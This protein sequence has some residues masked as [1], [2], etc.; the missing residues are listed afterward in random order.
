MD[1]KPFAL[2]LSEHGFTSMTTAGNRAVADTSIKHI[3]I[4]QLLILRGGQIL[5]QHFI[6]FLTM[7]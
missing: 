5:F 6:D 3:S 2:A 7:S 4:N 1:C